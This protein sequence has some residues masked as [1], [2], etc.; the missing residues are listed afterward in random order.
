MDNLLFV[1][2]GNPG[3]R[4]EN[5]RH[6]VGFMI[7]EALAE[8]DAFVS[9]KTVGHLAEIAQL[10]SSGRKVILA[11][12]LTFMNLS[13][14]AVRFLV[15]FYKIDINHIVVFHDDIDLPFGKVKIKQ[16]GGNGG[17]NGLKSIDNLVGNNYWRVRI[18]VDRP[19]EK[20]MVSSYVL[21]DFSD[22]QSDI[23]HQIAKTITD[24]VLL[25]PSDTQ[26]LM[27]RLNHYEK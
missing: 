24:N 3:K 19:L 2:L 10:S 22:E 8:A 23:I 27:E 5:N 11:R 7:I 14:Q 13:G 16:G 4:Y 21:G 18:G 25:L 6:N 1:G 20:S 17:H 9:F 12:P 15:D 26:K